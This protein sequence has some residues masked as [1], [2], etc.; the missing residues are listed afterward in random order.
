MILRELLFWE[1]QDSYSHELTMID[2]VCVKL[3]QDQAR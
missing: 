2:K 1:Q 3:K